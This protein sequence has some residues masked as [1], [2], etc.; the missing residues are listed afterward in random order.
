MQIAADPQDFLATKKGAVLN[1]NGYTAPISA[2]LSQ[3]DERIFAQ[4]KAF[5]PQVI[6]YVEY[7]LKSH[8]KGLRPTLALLSALATGAVTDEHLDLA[9]SVELIHLATLVHDDIIDGASQRRGLPTAVERWGAEVSVLLGDCLFAHALK[10]CTNL[11]QDI[12]REISEAVCQVCSGE[13]IQTQRRFDL[14]LSLEDYTHI[15]R[16]KTGALFRVPCE[17]AARL[18]HV[19]A[20]LA[21]SFRTYGE[22]L[23][24]AYQI[25]DDCLDLVG[26]EEASGKTLGTDLERGKVTLPVLY[27]LNQS[28]GAD[29]AHISE[30]ILN[31][32][33]EEKSELLVLVKE[34]GMLKQALIRLQTHLQTCRESL[35]DLPGS[36]ARD[37]LLE[38]PSV[39]ESHV[40]ELLQNG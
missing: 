13:I 6:P 40:E 20:L 14:T 5:D 17:L 38:I 7:A 39:L 37:S 30:V 2:Y 25:Y 12:N 8:G 3:L 34:R 31:G 32:T 19:P 27:L 35:G 4:A 1:L 28:N 33:T 26:N 24:V 21:G 23:G 18:N 16:L 29:K 36:P 9:V 10:L 22:N 15:I 11:P